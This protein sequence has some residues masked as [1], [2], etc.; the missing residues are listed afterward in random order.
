MKKTILIITLMILTGCSNAPVKNEETTI[1]KNISFHNPQNLTVSIDEF[2]PYAQG[3]N[4]YISTKPLS[5]FIEDCVSFRASRSDSPLAEIEYQR[6]LKNAFRELRDKGINKEVKM[7]DSLSCGATRGN[8]RSEPIEISD[9]N[10]IIYHKSLYQSSGSLTTFYTQVLVV[11]KLDQVHEL[12]FSYNFGELGK[13][14]ESHRDGYGGA[15]AYDISV[16][17]GWES[18]KTVDRWQEVVNYF[19]YQTPIKYEPLKEFE[20]NQDVIMSIIESIEIR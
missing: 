11:D 2:E 14:I 5:E 18:G 16:S 19:E 10:G 13:Y 15:Y 8:L 3:P 9:M 7:F 12:V 4:I 20:V 6:E 17:E 1:I